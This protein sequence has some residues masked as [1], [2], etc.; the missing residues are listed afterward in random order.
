M[1]C[2]RQQGKSSVMAITND[3]FVSYRRHNVTFAKQLVAALEAQGKSVWIDWEDIPPGVASFTDEIER[4]IDGAHIFL[5]VLSPEYLESPHCLAELQRAVAVNK[6]II[7]IVYEKFEGHNVPKHIHVINWIY[8]VPHA[9]QQNDFATAFA[10]MLRA[11]EADYEHIQEHTRL[12]QRATDW[13]KSGRNN[14]FLIGGIAL[15]NA[16]AWLSAASDKEPASAPLHTE[17]ILLSRREQAQRQR[18]LL[19]GTTVLLAIALIALIFAIQQ[20][21]VATRRA[22]ETLSLL[23]AND[24]QIA[25]KAGD[26]SVAINRAYYANTFLD[27]PPGA[28]QSVLQNVAF[29]PASRHIFSAPSNNIGLPLPVEVN[30]RIPINDSVYLQQDTSTELSLRDASGAVKTH[31]RNFTIE[32]RDDSLIHPDVMAIIKEIQANSMGVFEV[33]YDISIDGTRVVMGREGVGLI[34]WE[35]VA[36]APIIN[37]YTDHRFIVDNVQFTADGRYLISKS[38]EQQ[39]RNFVR[40]EVEYFIWDTSDW[41]VVQGITA[42]DD[43]YEL[44]AISDEGRFLI[45]LEYGSENIIIW[46]ASNGAIIWQYKTTDFLRDLAFTRDGQRLIASSV[47]TLRMAPPDT[48]RVFD[49]QTGEQQSLYEGIGSNRLIALPIL[50]SNDANSLRIIKDDG[51]LNL[52]NIENGDESSFGIL[53]AQF[54]VAG[55]SENGRY[56]AFETFDPSELQLYDLETITELGRISL[57]NFL[58]EVSISPD[59]RYVAYIEEAADNGSTALIVVELATGAEQIRY[60]NVESRFVVR[61]HLFGSN[62]RFIYADSDNLIHVVDTENWQDIQQ[63]TGLLEPVHDMEYN[64]NTQSLAVAGINGTVLVWDTVTGAINFQIDNIG[65]RALIAL[66]PAGD[67]LATGNE[68]GQI[69]VWRLFTPAETLAW[70]EEN[71]ALMPLSCADRVRYGLGDCD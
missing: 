24:A 47:I 61:A 22:D 60:N 43:S 39:N 63:L 1:M 70:V 67:G 18:R 42:F 65:N 64:A 15:N 16:E 20:F 51:T 34:V 55:I 59:R 17:F 68:F 71:R 50:F 9:G 56:I 40:S 7:P 62:R 32:S 28:A 33:G 37:T 23:I 69:I 10:S 52:L 3:V 29:Q 26:S 46:D 36:G 41:Q 54:S 58:R 14:S 45:F 2:F 48:I 11:I 49:S 5:A 30:T 21:L 31:F 12:L 6:R 66:T 4:G 38:S 27:N 35:N 8:F 53:S 44:S 25:A 57:V 19:A 13:D